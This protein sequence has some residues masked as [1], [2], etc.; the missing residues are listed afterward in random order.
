MRCI[1]FVMA[2]LSF[3][4]AA[5]AVR[6]P[7]TKIGSAVFGTAFFGM[8]KYFSFRRQIP[9]RETVVNNSSDVGA[10]PNN[11]TEV[12]IAAERGDIDTL[13]TLIKAGAN[14]HRANSDGITAL[15]LAAQGNYLRIFET[16]ANL[17]ADIYARDTHGFTPIEI[18]LNSPNRDLANF[19]KQTI[20]YP[21]RIELEKRDKEYFGK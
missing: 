8:L 9:V 10:N 7:F 1:L 14:I 4:E 6:R 21:T 17:G 15:H 20:E 13:I 16:L 12:M 2:A 18:A 5:P 19:A 3:S 11:Y